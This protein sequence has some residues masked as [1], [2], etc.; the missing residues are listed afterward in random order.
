MSIVEGEMSKKK[1][2]ENWDRINVVE[3]QFLMLNR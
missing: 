1:P 2:N 3:I